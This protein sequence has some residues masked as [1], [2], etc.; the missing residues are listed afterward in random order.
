MESGFGSGS[1]SA[2]C[3][4]PMRRSVPSARS[5]SAFLRA[6]SRP[7]R[8]KASLASRPSS[9]WSRIAFGIIG[10]LRRAMRYLLKSQHETPHTKFSIVPIF[11][12]SKNVA[13]PSSATVFKDSLFAASS[14]ENESSHKIEVPVPF[15]TSVVQW[16]TSSSRWMHSSIVMPSLVTCRENARCDDIGNSLFRGPLPLFGHR[17]PR[18]K[19]LKCRRL[20][21]SIPAAHHAACAKALSRLKG[22]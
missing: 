3:G 13:I 11:A 20:W 14:E 15:T 10:A 17:R 19:R 8:P 12:L 1:A 9:N 4:A 21:R 6:S 7:S 5:A 2:V 16:G 18:W 22:S